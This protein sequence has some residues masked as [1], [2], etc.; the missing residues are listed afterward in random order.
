MCSVGIFITSVRAIGGLVFIAIIC[1]FGPSSVYADCQGECN[2]PDPITRYPTHFEDY[3]GDG[4]TIAQG[5]CDDFDPLEYPGQK[6]YKDLDNDG[7]SDGT[8]L[9]ACLRPTSYKV[10]AELY[11]IAGDINDLI[12]DPQITSLPVINSIQPTKLIPNNQVTLLG[13]SFGA[14]RGSTY[15]KFYHNTKAAKILLWNNN[16]IVCEL[17]S[18][19]QSG[20][21]EIVTV[22][23]KSNCVKYTIA[24][25]MPW[26][27]LL[28]SDPVN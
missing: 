18:A 9:I 8:F 17:P 2:D 26:L 10:A 19:A 16:T 15:V 23:G 24:R 6:W 25:P 3:D 20:C 22:I 1:I 11:Q 4:Y 28:A 21:V 7:Y 27:L 13:S 14:F 5:D 12:P